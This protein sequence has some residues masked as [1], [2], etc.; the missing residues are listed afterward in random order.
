MEWAWSR[1]GAACLG[2]DLLRACPPGLP[3]RGGEPEPAG[4]AA[5]GRRDGQGRLLLSQFRRSPAGPQLP[6]RPAP[7]G[8]GAAG[9]EGL[10]GRARPTE[11]GKG[12]EGTEGKARDGVWPPWPLR[13]G[14]ALQELKSSR[15]ARPGGEEAGFLGH[16][17]VCPCPGDNRHRPGRGRGVGGVSG[18][19]QVPRR[20]SNVSRG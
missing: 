7:V 18:V 5:P 13:P 19:G 14:R 1:Q 15:R 17:G 3:P 6:Q 4:H 12:A 20:P 16:S 8:A 10:A 11:T 9:R 2:A